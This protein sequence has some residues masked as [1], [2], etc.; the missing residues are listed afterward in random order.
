MKLKES[1]ITF[2]IISN[3]CLFGAN[4]TDTRFKIPSIKPTV[5]SKPSI[6]EVENVTKPKIPAITE[7]AKSDLPAIDAIKPQLPTTPQNPSKADDSL[8]EK[9]PHFGT[10]PDF[11]KNK[12]DIYTLNNGKAIKLF[13]ADLE[14]S[15]TGWNIYKDGK[16]INTLASNSTK[17][18]DNDIVDGEKYEYKIVPVFGDKEGNPIITAVNSVDKSNN[19]QEYL[20]KVKEI[21]LN[22]KATD[23]D[24]VKWSQELKDGKSIIQIVEDMIKQKEFLSVYN[25]DSEYIKTVYEAL[26]G[27]KI[28]DNT[29]KSIYDK[30]ASMQISKPELPFFLANSKEFQ[31]V[32]DQNGIEAVD[33]DNIKAQESIEKLTDFVKRMYTDALGRNAESGGMNYWTEELLSGRKSAQQVA[34]SFFNSKEFTDK[35]LS[36]KEFL[37]RVYQTIMGRKPDQGGYDYWLGKLGNGSIDRQKLIDSFIYSPEFQKLAQDYGIK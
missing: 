23:S 29:F 21:L 5:P 37:D 7:P 18:I 14:D 31:Q 24:I 28:D 4:D 20:A 15:E 27:K 17:Y 9:I 35:Q 13:W 34:N 6:P 25:N 1:L 26:F 3:V 12:G 32:A 19:T 33:P 11:P 16:L 30:I 2:V 22:K 36:D 8:Q 10:F